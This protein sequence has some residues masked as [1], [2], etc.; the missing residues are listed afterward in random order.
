MRTVISAALVVVVVVFGM[1][2]I[3]RAQGDLNL[4]MTKTQLPDEVTAIRQLYTRA[5]LACMDG[6]GA[7]NIWITVDPV[8]KAMN[9]TCSFNPNRY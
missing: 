9:Y 2:E 7:T 1:F 8:S 4:F 3:G 5:K 6:A